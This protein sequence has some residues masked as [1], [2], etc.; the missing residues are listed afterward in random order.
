MRRWMS[1]PPPAIWVRSSTVERPVVN[2]LVAGSSPAGPSYYRRVCRQTFPRRGHAPGGSPFRDGCPPGLPGGARRSGGLR[3]VNLRRRSRPRREPE[4]AE[5]FCACRTMVSPPV[6]QT[7][8]GGFDSPQAHDDR[9]RRRSFGPVDVGYRNYNGPKVATLGRPSQRSAGRTSPK[10][11]GACQRPTSLTSSVRTPPTS[12]PRHR[13]RW[14]LARNPYLRPSGGRVHLPPFHGWSTTWRTSMTEVRVLP[15][16]PRAQPATARDVHALHRLAPAWASKTHATGFDSLAVCHALTGH[17]PE[18]GT[19]RYER[20][21]R[22]FESFRWHDT[23]TRTG[24]PRAGPRSDLGRGRAAHIRFEEGSTP[25]AAT[26]GVPICTS[27]PGDG[28]H[29]DGYWSCWF[30]SNHPDRAGHRRP[31]AGVV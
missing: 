13:S 19:R 28:P 27:S 24:A 15:V 22:G 11:A 4:D 16:A 31:H 1:Q 7:G 12:R 20:R 5:F 21:W 8:Y 30:E 14:C 3:G 6:P 10:V 23:D 18:D 25:S 26:L 9:R 17:R 2:R 29:M